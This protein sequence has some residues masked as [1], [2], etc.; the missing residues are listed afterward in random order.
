MQNSNFYIVGIGASA[1]GY[2]AL[3]EFF[4][5]LPPDPG[6][7]FVVIQHLSREYKSIADKLLAK[8]TSLPV[9]KAEHNQAVEVNTIYVI[10]ENKVITIKN[11]RLHLEQRSP[12]ERINFTVDIFFHSLAADAQEKAIGIVL[13]GLGSDG[14]KGVQ[15]I[16]KYRGHVMV[17]EPNS[18]IFSS[19]PKMAIH[20][21][22]PDFILSPAK[23]AQALVKGMGIGINK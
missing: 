8:H 5:H 20:A 21:D 13:S 17:Q 10:P 1:G 7:A 14:A 22:S 11:R 12:Y 9:Y 19:M 23:L 3:W 6:A 15:S 4:S 16:H 2:E 18:T